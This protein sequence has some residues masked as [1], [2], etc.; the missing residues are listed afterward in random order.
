M[1]NFG[2]MDADMN[3]RDRELDLTTDERKK[4]VSAIFEREFLLQPEK[5]RDEFLDY[6]RRLANAVESVE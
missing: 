6:C 3:D 1:G 4:Y 2:Q 5:N